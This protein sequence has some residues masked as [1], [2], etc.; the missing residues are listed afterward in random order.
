MK[1]KD[2]IHSIKKNVKNLNK[3]IGQNYLISIRILKKI[4][5]LLDINDKDN[6]LEVGSG[7]GNL[8][9]F[10]L[11]SNCKK[12]TLN[13]ID[14]KN[15]FF[16]KKII[17]NE[18]KIKIIDFI[19]KSALKIN[20]SRYSKI[21]S[22]L[23]YYITH[24]LLEYFMVH[25][26]ALKYVFMVQKEVFEKISAKSNTSYYGPLNILIS[27]VGK[28]KKEFFVSKENF[29]PVPHINSVVFSITKNSDVSKI[30]RHKYVFF[31]KKIFAH[32]RKTI[33]NN[34]TLFLKNKT[35]VKR[36]LCDL[37]ISETTRPE[38]ICSSVYLNIFK[39]INKF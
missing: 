22:N 4:V 6:V 12:I 28:I 2:I 17:K 1:I 21:I 35:K 34:L 24:D 32:R 9:F 38:Q 3:E 19:N 31:L 26:N 16:L 33:F 5:S 7:L 13:D 14:D 29:L 23:P 25:G 39:K 15:I 8:S 11:K 18:R 20:I 37:K 30:N 27:Y 10:L 36:I